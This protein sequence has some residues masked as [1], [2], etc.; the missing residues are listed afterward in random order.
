VREKTT[1]TAI[2][3]HRIIPAMA[4]LAMLT[5]PVALASD[6]AFT[7]PLKYD[8][9]ELVPCPEWMPEGCG[10][11]VLQGNPAENNADILFRLPA[12]TTAD[13]HWHSSAERMV[14]IAGTMSVNFDGQDPVTL[15]P[16]TYAYG[17]ARLPHTARCE[18][19]EDCLLFIAFEGPV[20]AHLVED[21]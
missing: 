2:L 15:R 5:T 16:G 3:S 11:A 18:S 9:L 8:A 13:H 7:L 6:K 12:N 14:L 21:D 1:W 17:P 20:D 10:I 19:D 4:L